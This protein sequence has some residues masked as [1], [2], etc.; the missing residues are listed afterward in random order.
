[1]R[2]AAGDGELAVIADDAGGFEAI[3]VAEELLQR[4]AEVTLLTRLD[5]VGAAMPEPQATV[6]AARERLSGIPRFQH[7]AGA[8]LCELDE[9]TFT[10]EWVGTPRREVLAADTVVVVSVNTPARELADELQQCYSGPVHLV[11]DAATRTL[12][13]AIAGGAAAAAAV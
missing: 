10:A 3:S 13:E 9:L 7:I 4:G 5:S 6:A 12:R 8:V 11:G 1:M 2:G